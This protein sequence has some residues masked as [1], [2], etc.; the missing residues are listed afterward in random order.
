VNL[1]RVKQRGGGDEEKRVEEERNKQ[2]EIVQ[3]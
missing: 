1:E 3:N 2:S